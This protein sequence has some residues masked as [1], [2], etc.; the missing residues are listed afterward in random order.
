DGTLTM[1][2]GSL[3]GAGTETVRRDGHVTRVTPCALRFAGTLTDNGLVDV[4]SHTLELTATTDT[5]G[6]SGTLNIASGATVDLD[7]TLTMQ[8]GSLFGSGTGT[9]SI[10][11]TGKLI[12]QADLSFAG[13]LTDNGLVD[14]QS[15]TLELTATTDMV[16]SSGT[17]N[18]A[19]GATVDLDGTLTMQTG[20]LFGAGTGTLSIDTTGKLITQADLSFAGTLTDN[21]LVDVQSHTLELTATTDTVGSSGTLNIASGATVDLD[22]TLTMQTGS[23]FGAGIGTLSIDTTGKLITQADLSFAGTLTDNGLVDVQSHTLE[24]TATTDTV[25]SSGTL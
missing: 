14:V 6:S 18:I 3:F 8:T 12:T 10:D 1:Q 7:G 16:G 15:H 25:G 4:Q 19:S 24:L 5:V 22:G 11:T 20:S 17:L 21:G 23:L 2:T 9:L 13:T